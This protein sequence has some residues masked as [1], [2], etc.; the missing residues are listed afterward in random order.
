MHREGEKL[1]PQFSQHLLKIA[2]FSRL[3]NWGSGR[4]TVL[5]KVTAKMG[6]SQDLTP[7]PIPKP[8]LLCPS[9][10]SPTWQIGTPSNS[11]QCSLAFEFVLSSN[12][13]L[14]FLPPLYCHSLPLPQTHSQIQP[15]F[16]I[17][18]SRGYT[19]L[20]PLLWGDSP[21]LKILPTMGFPAGPEPPGYLSTSL[22]LPEKTVALR[23]QPSKL[24]FRGGAGVGIL[25][26]DFKSQMKYPRKK[27]KAKSW[28]NMVSH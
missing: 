9:K 25:N 16:M 4:W 10:L 14:S 11:R 22:S 8:I 5:P 27:E 17:G 21:Q 6:Q 24:L 12:S 1:L 23:S 13:S 19:G 7:G 26:R 18:S 20:M 15:D 28:K 2:S 3:E